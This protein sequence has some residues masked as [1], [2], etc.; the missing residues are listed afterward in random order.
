MTVS[1]VL[2]LSFLG[3]ILGNGNGLEGIG[4]G[5]LRVST[6]RKEAGCSTRICLVPLGV[7][8]EREG[9]P[10]QVVCYRARGE[11]GGWIWRREGRVK[12]YS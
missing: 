11:P 1:D 9:R 2:V 8:A 6:G 4:G 10:Q 12:I 5:E 7:G 3:V